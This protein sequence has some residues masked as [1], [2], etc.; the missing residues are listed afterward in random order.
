MKKR[1]IAVVFGGYSSENVVSRRS[2]RGIASFLDS[3]LYNIYLV[4]I[5]HDRWTVEIE[6]SEPIDIDRSDFSFT[7]AGEKIHFDLAYITIRGSPGEN[8]ILQ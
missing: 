8:G 1:N 2:A 6:G 7:C 5:E 3:D 4:D